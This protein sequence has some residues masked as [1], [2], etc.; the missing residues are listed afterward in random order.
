MSTEDKK[1]SPDGM[2]IAVLYGLLIYHNIF[3]EQD[4]ISWWW[5]VGVPLI[6]FACWVPMAVIV[7]ILR[8]WSERR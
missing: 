1:L 6:Y 8:E 7:V 3:R 5:L 4:H 2:L